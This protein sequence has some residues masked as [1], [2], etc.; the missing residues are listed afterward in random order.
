MKYFW[1]WFHSYNSCLISLRRFAWWWLKLYKSWL[2]FKNIIHS[3]PN[4][5]KK[6]ERTW[7][8]ND[9][10][11]S[12]KYVH[13]ASPT[14]WRHQKNRRL[15]GK[16]RLSTENAWCSK[17]FQPETERGYKFISSQYSK[18]ILWTWKIPYIE[19]MWT[20]Y[21]K[22]SNETENDRH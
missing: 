11:K 3:G 5:V 20:T 9:S 18:G 15:K 13:S 16:W 21:N 1:W 7:I 14:F 19:P 4:V 2:S 6:I 10:K 17:P 8:H 22:Y 12:C